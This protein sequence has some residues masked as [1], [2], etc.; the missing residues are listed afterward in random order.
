MPLYIPQN[1]DC[2]SGQNCLPLRQ[3]LLLPPHLLLQRLLLLH[4]PLSH[5]QRPPKIGRQLIVA[6]GQLDNLFVQVRDVLSELRGLMPGQEGL[7]I[8][9]QLAALLLQMR[10]GV[11]GLLALQ[12]VCCHGRL[13]AQHRTGELQPPAERNLAELSHPSASSPQRRRHL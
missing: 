9:F 8:G 10:Y 13:Q 3:L 6:H 11:E 4:H 7:L 1:L 12:P 5:I 2:T